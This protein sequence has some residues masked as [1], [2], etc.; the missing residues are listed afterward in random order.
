MYNAK[1]RG[2]DHACFRSMA[3]PDTVVALEAR[4][5]ESGTYEKPSTVAAI[6]LESLER[7]AEQLDRQRHM[8]GRDGRKQQRRCVPTPCTLRYIFPPS[9]EVHSEP[10][11]VRTI[12]T[13]G[14]G[15]LT[16]RSMARGDL[17]EVEFERD[18]DHVFIAGLVAFSRHVEDAIHEVGVQ[19]FQR[20]ERPIL[21]SGP[22]SAFLE[23]EWAARAINDWDES[24]DVA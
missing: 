12:S 6:P 1:R 7:V 5:S 20:S 10:A 8:T 15:L 9:R 23:A 3:Q 2:K 17:V 16:S 11:F 19:L 18:G 14:I 24:R 4:A 21:S 22:N 13:G